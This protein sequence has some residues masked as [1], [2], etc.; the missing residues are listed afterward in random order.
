MKI[1]FSIVSSSYTSTEIPS[2]GI[3]PTTAYIPLLKIVEESISDLYKGLVPFFVLQP[4][5]NVCFGS[6]IIFYSPIDV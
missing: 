2:V 1:K 5:I 3:Y 4:L 6:L